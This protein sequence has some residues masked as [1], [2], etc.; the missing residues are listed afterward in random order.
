MSLQ[1]QPP[2]I[3]LDW[4]ERTIPRHLRE[5]V[6]GDLEEE[7][8]SRA[9]K[10]PRLAS[11]WYCRH[12]AALALRLGWFDLTHKQPHRDGHPPRQGDGLMETLWNDVRFGARML[13]R[14]PG[15]TLVAVLTLALGI[16]A[17][18]AIFSIVN[19]VLIKPLPLPE[20]ERL[21]SLNGLD[22]KGRPQFIS[23]PDFADLQRQAT[24]F[25]GF[26]AMVPQS[27]NLTGRAEP[28][29][30][31]GGFVSD[32]FFKIS[33][34]E[35]AMGRG[36]Q[37]GDDDLGAPL[38][39]VLQ[40]ETWQSLFEADP[41]ILGK[42]IVINNTPYSVVGVLPRGFRFVFDEVEVWMPHHSWP[43]FVTGQL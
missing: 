33:G 11:V 23:F 20:S 41:G 36:F 35:V 37:R 7:W 5:S 15:F 29:R 13:W 19:A 34:V 31:R 32:N 6:L 18:T 24:L 10:R 21:L 42:S 14:T 39:C 25:E 27:A 38:V 22:P 30:V 40:H 43:V 1:K 12:A 2:R 28:T 17:N 8:R 16:G 9:A 26:S 3:A 4:L